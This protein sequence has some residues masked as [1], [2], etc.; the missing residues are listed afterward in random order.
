MSTP[1]PPI[2]S[3]VI[4]TRTGRPGVVMG[5]EGPYVQLRPVGG[6][7]EWD[8][9]PES[10]H[11][12][13]PTG[14]PGAAGCAVASA[15]GA[16][17]PGEPVVPMG[18]TVVPTSHAEEAVGSGSRVEGP[19]GSARGAEEPVG[20]V[21]VAAAERSG[22][23]VGAVERPVGTAGAAECLARPASVP[24]RTARPAHPLVTPAERPA[25]PLISPAERPTHSIVPPAVAER[26]VRPVG[27]GERPG[28]AAGTPERAVRAAGVPEGPPRAAVTP[29]AARENPH[30]PVRD[31][32][33][34]RGDV[35]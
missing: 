11:H 21:R 6:G 27:P 24:E 18:A 1:K 28:C 23:A 19:V 34:G 7:R 26:T 15:D 29:E 12:L 10:L 17:R 3:Y 5:H 30:D 33:R 16:D 4:D 13:A 25:H 32:L 22:P 2:G 8:C 14:E 31:R 35:P 9:V 20:S